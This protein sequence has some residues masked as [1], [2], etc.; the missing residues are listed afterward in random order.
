MKR[1]ILSILVISV[2]CVG[3]GALVDKAGAN[4]KSDEKALVLIQKS[5]Q[6]IGGDAALA[7]VQ[8]MVIIGKTSRTLKTDG[9]ERNVQGEAEIAMQLPDKLM[10]MIKIG[11]GDGKGE[12]VKMIDKE[13]NVGAAAGEKGKMDVT[14]DTEDGKAVK[15]IVIKKD[16][17]TVQEFTGEE[18]DKI[19]AADAASGKGVKTIVIKSPDGTTKTYTGAEADKV[20]ARNGD[21]TATWTSKDGKTINIEN[22]VGGH[23]GDKHESM[24]HNEMLRLTL[25]LLLTAPQGMDVSYTFGGESSIDGTACNIVNAEFGGSTFKLHLGQTSNLPVALVYTGMKMPKVMMFKSEGAKAGEPRDKEQTV[26]LRKA[27]GP[28]METAEFTVKFADFRSVNGVQLPFKWTQT[29][30]GATDEIF[31]VTSYDINPANIAERFKNQKVMVRTKK[32]DAQ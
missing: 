30:G 22:V 14:V 6:A 4:F 11:D 24:R 12:G 9:A 10:K 29:V 1:F 32:N 2:F 13:V 17:G 21:S 27:D 19:I 7:N 15:K 26:F 23:S 5:R 8:S 28:P 3:L 20:A 18:A 31:D 25:S 16:D